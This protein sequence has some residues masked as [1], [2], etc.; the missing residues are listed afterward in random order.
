MELNSLIQALAKDLAEQLRPMVAEMVKQELANADGE[1]ALEGI[2]QNIN[3]S[4]LVEHIDLANLAG[5]L[6]DSQLR[7]IAGHIS[8]SDLAGDINLSD[9]AGEFDADKVAEAIDLDSAINDW[10]A[11]QSFTIRP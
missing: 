6:R 9:L 7:I 10:F 5:E 3:L 1:N 2:A 8:L 4:E 11:D